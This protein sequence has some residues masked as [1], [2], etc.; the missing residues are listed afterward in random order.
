MEGKPWYQSKT[1]LFNVL[2]LLVSVAAVFGFSSFQPEPKWAEAIAA[3]VAILNIVLRFISKD[4][5]K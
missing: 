4:P 1:V 3:V 5:I 2:F